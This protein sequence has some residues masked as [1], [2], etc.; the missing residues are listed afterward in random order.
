MDLALSDEQRDAYENLILL[1]G[2][3]HRVVDGQPLD[4]PVHVLLELKRA[5][6]AWVSTRLGGSSTRYLGVPRVSASFEGRTAIT[7]RARSL[8]GGPN[9]ARVALTGPPGIGKSAIAT[10]LAREQKPDGFFAVF[11]LNA[12]DDFEAQWLVLANQCGLTHCGSA[13]E[14]VDAVDSFERD[15]VLVVVDGVVGELPR[16]LPQRTPVLVTANSPN[17]GS[18]ISHHLPI[19]QLDEDSTF[20]ILCK[21]SQRQLLIEECRP[22]LEHVAGHA[23]TAEL[24]ANLLAFDAT[25]SPS[26]VLQDIRNTPASL[27][28]VASL[29]NYQRTTHQAL[30]AMW[31]KLDHIARRTL[32]LMSTIQSQMGSIHIALLPH[33]QIDTAARVALQRVGLVNAVP[34]GFRIHDLLCRIALTLDAD[35][36]TQA[37]F[38][39]DALRAQLPALRQSSWHTD[40]GAA[41][42]AG[43]IRCPHCNSTALIPDPDSDG[44][45]TALI[46]LACLEETLVS[47]LLPGLLADATAGARYEAAKE[48]DE[49]PVGQCPECNLETYDL[50]ADEC[51]S[52][53][54]SVRWEDAE[55][56][57]CG[58]RLSLGE[59]SEGK[60]SY[61][62]YMWDK[63]MNDDD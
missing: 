20:E 34:Y 8:L 10:V 30:S 46:C 1:C 4:Y 38:E 13:E 33:A 11:W 47:K 17:L 14:V 41:L 40:T 52:C 29:T 24:V 60:C 7:D 62:Q 3:C 49:D 37:Q 15:K 56:S 21:V 44:D 18:W 2:T 39:V 43:E 5:H 32:V 45:Y 25:V 35:L 26:S 12:T 63:L 61:H 55:C 48:G 27:E 9:P 31:T 53:G 51:A 16:L 50:R 36:S 19:D 23:L 54:Y 42:L 58:C 59:L 6:E 28:T 57:I 22:L